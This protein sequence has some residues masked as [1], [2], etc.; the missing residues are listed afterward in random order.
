MSCRWPAGCSPPSRAHPA[1]GPLLFVV[2]TP[3][4]LAALWV[5]G[6]YREPARSIGGMSLQDMFNGLTAVTTASWLLLIVLV[7]VGH[8]APVAYLIAFWAGQRGAG[9]RHALAA[10]PPVVARAVVRRARAHR[11]RRRRGPH[12]GR[13]DRQAP[14]VPR[15]PAGLPGRR[16]AAP[17][18]QR[19][20]RHGAGAGP[21]VGPGARGGAQARA[22]RHRGLHPQPPQRRAARGAPVRGPRRA[23]QHRAAPVRGGELAGARGRRRGHPAAGHRPRGARPLQH[24]REAR[25]RPG[26]GRPAVRAAAARCWACSRCSSSSTRPGRCSSARSA[27]GAAGAP[28]A[29]TSSAP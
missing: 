22:P 18:R 12:P 13:Q 27:W 4:W 7:F 2:L 1:G 14:R 25:L 23:R 19:R 3:Y 8:H 16:R 6:L 11:G 28:F 24:G 15:G 9:A 10:A 26:A 21:P 29:S 17:Q 20:R 5:F